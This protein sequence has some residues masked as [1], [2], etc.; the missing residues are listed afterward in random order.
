MPRP[1]SA[2]VSGAGVFRGQVLSPVPVR[3]GRSCI[4]GRAL[5]GWARGAASGSRFRLPAPRASCNGSCSVSR[6][7]WPERQAFPAL[8][9]RG[10][11]P[12][13]G[14]G[15]S[16]TSCSGR[17]VWLGL[18]TLRRA[19]YVSFPGCHRL[20]VLA[21]DFGVQGYPLPVVSVGSGAGPLRFP[22]AAFQVRAQ[23]A[24]AAIGQ[25]R[26]PCSSRRA[27]VAPGSGAKALASAAWLRFC[28][29]ALCSGFR[30]GCFGSG[31]SS[32][33]GLRGL[34][35]LP[36]RGTAKR[37]ALCNFEQ[38]RLLISCA[39]LQTVQQ[40]ARPRLTGRLRHSYCTWIK[41]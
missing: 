32:G 37:L 4:L 40:H 12:R 21:Q 11:G 22:G 9:Q 15:A 7:P 35:I 2:S 20:R 38:P 13:S 30:G 18:E 3:K 31:S 25:A 41:D 34:Q 5:S 26:A 39:F 16:S 1:A 8:L 27:G 36:P 6:F 10:S 24:G 19:R 28:E 14:P 23:S 33:A 17:R 29:R